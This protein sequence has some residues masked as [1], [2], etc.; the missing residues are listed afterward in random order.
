MLVCDPVIIDTMVKKVPLKNVTDICNYANLQAA[1][2]CY[3]TAHY[4][5]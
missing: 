5:K 3:N 4:L 2:S 1:I